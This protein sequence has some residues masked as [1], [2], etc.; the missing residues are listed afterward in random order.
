MRAGRKDGAVGIRLGNIFE[1]FRHQIQIVPLV[2]SAINF[3]II[4]YRRSC[5]ERDLRAHASTCQGK[6]VQ[7][8]PNIKE[9]TSWT[10]VGGGGGRALYHLKHAQLFT[11]GN[12]IVG[13]L[14]QIWLLLQ[15]R[16][17]AWVHFGMNKYK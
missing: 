3:G 11:L 7:P 16:N 4:I 17:D 8:R 5:Y 15:T 13:I 9:P 1:S 2:R 10:K 6:G 12:I 14:A